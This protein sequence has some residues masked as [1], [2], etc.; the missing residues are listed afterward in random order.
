VR[1]GIGYDL[2]RLVPGKPLV[3]GGVTVP[4]D[5]GLE[6]HSDADVLT[7][8]VIDALLGAGCLGN[9]GEHFPDTAPEYKDADSLELLKETGRKTHDAGYA[10]GNIDAV[11][12]AERPRL[13][14]FVPGMRETLAS[15]LGISEDAVSVKPKTNEGVGPEGAGEAIS[16]Y[17]VAALEPRTD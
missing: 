4:F 7:H 3:L 8:A 10:I 6:G 5:K 17:A 9:I 15:A 13:S 1:I 16:A 12:V 11:L 2:H 14:P